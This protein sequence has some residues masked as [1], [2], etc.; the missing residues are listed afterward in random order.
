MGEFGTITPKD[1]DSTLSME[2]LAGVLTNIIKEIRSNPNYGKQLRACI[3]DLNKYGDKIA[4]SDDIEVLFYIYQNIQKTSMELRRLLSAFINLEVYDS[5]NYSL[6]VKGQRVALEHL[7]LKWLSK[8]TSSGE[9]KLKMAGALNALEEEVKDEYTEQVNKIF[10]HHYAVFL[11]AIQGTYNGTLGKGALNIGHVAEAYESHIE[12]HHPQ[13]YR[14]L[15]NISKSGADLSTLDKMMIAFAKD[16]DA[17]KYWDSHE[18]IGK[19][20]IHIRNSL[21]TQRGT[22]AGDVGRMQVK[23][24][25]DGS[26]IRL[27]R[28]NTLQEGLTL[29]SAIIGE[30]PAETVAKKIAEYISE[31]VKQVSAQVIDNI[32]DE[33]IREEFKKTNLER[34]MNVMVHI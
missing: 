4:K 27:A 11:Q 10:N 3:A 34:Q 20:W 12:E 33:A 16:T 29:Y 18:G 7:D 13:E 21:G 32:K 28:F 8:S 23:Q 6:Y 2:D 14:V 30:E 5:I 26:R 19:A 17:V 9:L 24:S 25:K 1:L 15:N 31:P 22:V